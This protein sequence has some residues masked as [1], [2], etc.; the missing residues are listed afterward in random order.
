[1]SAG[2]NNTNANALGAAIA[3]ALNPSAPDTAHWQTICQTIYQHLLTDILITIGTGAITTTGSATTQ[4]G[5][6]API[7][8]FPSP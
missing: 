4:V 5:P 8:M 6:P 1:M 3:S 2:L 7:P